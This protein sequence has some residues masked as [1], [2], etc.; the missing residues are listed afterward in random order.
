MA[1]VNL[2]CRVNRVEL[3]SMAD[4]LLARG[5]VLGSAKEAEVV[6]VNTC[7]VTGEAEAKTRKTLRHAARNPQ[8]RH[9]VA[10]GCVANLFSEE[11]E[12]LGPK[13]VVEPLKSE[14]P[15]RVA[16]LM[17]LDSADPVAA[18]GALPDTITPTGRSRPGIKVQDGCDNRCTYCI[19]WKARGPARS[20]A[21]PEVVA[22]VDRAVAAGAGEV[23]LTGID[24]GAYHDGP[25]D[26]AGLVAGLLEKTR[27]GRLRLS[28]VEPAEVTDELIA[29]MA[30]NPRRVAPFLHL[31]LQ[32]GSD[33]TLAEM[34]RPYTTAEYRAVVERVRAAVPD[35]ALACDLIVGFPGEDA[36]RFQ[37]SL[38][39]CREMAFSHMH[40]FRYS[41]RPGTPAAARPDQVA[42][43]ELARRSREMRE[44]SLSMA[45]DYAEAQL[46]R[47]QWVAVEEEGR[48]VTGGLLEIETLP[49]AV[50]GTFME[51]V[52]QRVLAGPKLA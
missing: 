13:V 28:S 50:P 37:E 23:V 10:T 16:A 9:V 43:E 18:E 41:K 32:A 26:L 19:V 49:E 6:V 30:A 52:P 51:L 15:A 21:F 34:G 17:G 29:L 25:R 1:L 33:R 46:G 36:E 4:G 35:V 48:G 7:A 27:V 2:G 3:D 8:V 24:L 14:V 45:R 42:P 39:F 38:D 31:P 20:M 5:F 40:V 44:L 22:E 12:A 47:V 11:L